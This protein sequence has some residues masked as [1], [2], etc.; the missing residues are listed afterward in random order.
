MEL[1]DH[2]VGRLTIREFNREYQYYKDMFDYE[3]L[4][5]LTRKTYAQAKREARQAEEWF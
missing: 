5:K 4:L 3:L 2:Q 1:T